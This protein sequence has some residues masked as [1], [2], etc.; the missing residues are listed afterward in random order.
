MAINTL[1]SKL[2]HASRSL[3][4]VEIIVQTHWVDCFEGRAK[5]I[6]NEHKHYSTTEMKMCALREACAV[7]GWSE[8]EL[9][10]RLYEFFFGTYELLFF[11]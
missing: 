3:R 6:G 2:S 9:R 11:C 8:K 5:A 4:A 1:C 7:L 10:N